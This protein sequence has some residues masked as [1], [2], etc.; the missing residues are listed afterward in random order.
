MTTFT[1]SDRIN[2]EPIPFAGMMDLKIKQ[3]SDEWHQLRLGKVTASRVVDVMSKIKTGESAGRKNYKMDLVV[4]RLTGLPTSSFTSPAMAWGTETEPLARMAYEAHFGTFVD[5]VAFIQHP[6]IE[7]FGCSPD[8]LIGDN[9]L[10]IKCP[11]TANHIDYLLAGIPP[12]K[13]VPQM[14]TQMACTGAKWCDF[15]SFDPRLPSELQLF[16]VRLD[17]D[18]AYIQQI[19]TEVK[20]FL[21]EVKQVYTQL[22]ERS[23]GH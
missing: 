5:T 20:Q 3:G 18:E 2:C 15:V 16:V 1:T 21:E 19:E 12:A 23:Y 11:N 6:T 13:Y 7:W 9:L 22:K 8:G 10:E 4:E 17:R 14:Q